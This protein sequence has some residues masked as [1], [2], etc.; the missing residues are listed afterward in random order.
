MTLRRR[1]EAKLTEEIGHQAAGRLHRHRPRRRR[2]ARGRPR[3]R[4]LLRG[5]RTGASRCCRS[6]SGAIRSACSRT[7]T[8]RSTSRGRAPRSSPG[9]RS[10]WA[11]WSPRSSASASAGTGPASDLAHA[12]RPGRADGRLV[13]H[14]G[15]A[16]L[17]RRRSRR[18]RSAERTWSARSWPTAR[19]AS[20]WR[21]SSRRNARSV[22]AVLE[23]NRDVHAALRDA[24]IA[25]DE[26]VRDEI[27]DG[28]REGARPTLLS[29]AR[30]L[31]SSRL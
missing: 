6:S 29:V 3:D 4:R 11:V 14:G 16:D 9:S 25:R 8:T 12:T 30:R 26:L 19:V 24:L 21:T 5:H 27:L 13:R 31:F 22:L 23:E 10:P 28:H 18:A 17:L 7:G 1:Y 20:A 15:V 2:H